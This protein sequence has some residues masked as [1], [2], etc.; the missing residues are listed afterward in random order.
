MDELPL[1]RRLFFDEKEREPMHASYIDISREE[2]EDQL[3]LGLIE[4]R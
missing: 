2:L 3:R 1:S 4:G